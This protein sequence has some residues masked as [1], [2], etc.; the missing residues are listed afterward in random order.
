MD[1]SKMLKEW[2]ELSQRSND[3]EDDI[4]ALLFR[5]NRNDKLLADKKAEFHAVNDK[6]RKLG[7]RMNK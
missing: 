3:L 5:L 2:K 4:A 7:V 6:L 1:S